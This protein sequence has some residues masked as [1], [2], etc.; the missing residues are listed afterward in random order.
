MESFTIGLVSN[1]SAQLIPGNTLSCFANFLP[2]QL[3]LEGKWEVA[4]PETSY[5][6]MYQIVTEGK[7]MFFDKRNFQ[8]GLNFTIWLLPLHYGY[9]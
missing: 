4:I 5:P 9:C 1:A 6:S 7:F 3:N 2:E 8:S